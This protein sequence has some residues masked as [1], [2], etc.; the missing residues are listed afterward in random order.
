MSRTRLS[1]TVDEGLLASARQV[2]PGG[3][4]AALMDEALAAL[5]ERHRR[6]EIDASYAAYDEHPLDQPDEWGDLATFRRLAGGS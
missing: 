2:R 1:T 6:A 3:T 5:L 4:D